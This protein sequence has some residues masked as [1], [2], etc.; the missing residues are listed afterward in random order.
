MSSPTR[1]VSAPDPFG[2]D[3]VVALLDAL[4]L[5]PNG[6]DLVETRWSYRR[7]VRVGDELR[8]EL[9]TVRRDRAVLTWHLELSTATGRSASGAPRH[10]G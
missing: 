3:T 6:S 9:V 5:A 4:G 7:P 10:S 1:V 2:T 8:L